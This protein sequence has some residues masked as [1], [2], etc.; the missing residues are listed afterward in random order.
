[1]GWIGVHE[2]GEKILIKAFGESNSIW[3][4]QVGSG[5]LY[6][7]REF[8]G[9]RDLVA[10]KYSNLY[11]YYNYL[12]ASNAGIYWVDHITE[13]NVYINPPDPEREG[14]TFTG[15]YPDEACTQTWGGTM[16]ASAE[17]KLHLY[18]GWRENQ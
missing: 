7:T 3:N 16:P 5:I 18:A 2:D 6:V 1:M 13:T 9:G 12:G 10:A 14:Y 15:W 8:T 4:A 11:Y 17:E